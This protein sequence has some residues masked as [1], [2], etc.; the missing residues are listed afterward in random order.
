VRRLWLAHALLGRFLPRLEVASGRPPFF[1]MTARFRSHLELRI[2][3]FA[4]KK[5]SKSQERQL[6]LN[7]D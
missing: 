3:N 5:P 4:P 2:L 1:E 7:I 6:I